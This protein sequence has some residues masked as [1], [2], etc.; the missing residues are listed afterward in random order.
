MQIKEEPFKL[1]RE[2]QNIVEKNILMLLGIEFIRT[3]FSLNSFRIDSL[4]FD[5]EKKSFVIIEYKRDRNFSV[6]DQGYAYLS[7]MLNNKADFILEYNESKSARLKRTDV[8]WSQSK[9]IFVSP[10]FTT[11]QKEAVNFKDLPIELWEIKRFS[12]NTLSFEQIIS[13][14]SRES[15]KA[16]SNNETMTTVS[17]E[18]K[19]YNEQDH[20]ARTDESIR[21]IYEQIKEYLLSLGDDIS[22]YPKKQTIGFKV[23]NKVFCDIVIQNKGIRLFLNV[24]KGILKDPGN[25]M[26]DVSEVGHWGN[27]AYEISFPLNDDIEIEY[28]FNLLRQTMYKNKDE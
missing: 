13:K 24:K 26:R 16:I 14:S 12:N 23:G 27:G 21:N 4:A 3:E 8:D 25:I 28:V 7:L 20:L 9:V 19:I 15:I 18:I 2:I 17:K 10:N 22:I 6:I 1:E 11:Y 5:T